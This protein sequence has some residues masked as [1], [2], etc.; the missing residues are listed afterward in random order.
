MNSKKRLNEVRKRW[1]D[2]LTERTVNRERVVRKL[3]KRLFRGG[4]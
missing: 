3:K 1:S 2:V 4:G